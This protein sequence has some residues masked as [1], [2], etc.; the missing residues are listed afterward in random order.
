MQADN[1]IANDGIAQFG[2]ASFSGNFERLD[3]AFNKVASTAGVNYLLTPNLALYAR[4]ARAFQA[5][6]ENRPTDLDFAEGGIRYQTG[7][8][9]RFA[10]GV[11]YAVQGLPVLTPARRGAARGELRIRYQCA[12]RRVRPGMDAGRLVPPSG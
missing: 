9:P 1:I 6:G 7:R 3:H 10:D 2:G 5:Q 11:P 12:R 8:I 4:Y